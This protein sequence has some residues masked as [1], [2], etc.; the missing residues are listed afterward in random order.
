M[1]KK[2]G[3]KQEKKVNKKVN[4]KVIKGVSKKI[5]K[6]AN[7]KVIKEVKA[8]KGVSSG[9]ALNKP[10]KVPKKSPITK[11]TT[12]QK[13]KKILSKETWKK[14]RD[15]KGN[16][17]KGRKKSLKL[18]VKGDKNRYQAIVKTISDYN[19]KAGTPLKRKDL[20]K[21]YRR[22]RDTYSN[23]PLSV[24]IPQFNRIVIQKKAT[25][26]F[27]PSLTLG[28]PWYQ[29][30]DEMTAGFAQSYFR[31]N[32]EIV[33]DLGI[34]NPSIPNMRFPYSKI[35]GNYKKLYNNISFR[36]AVKMKSTYY[37]FEYDS[38]SSNVKKGIYVFVLR[39]VSSGTGVTQTP[40]QPIVKTPQQQAPTLPGPI[41]DLLG[42]NE[43]GEYIK[44]ITSLRDVQSSIASALKQ[45][46]LTYIQYRIEMDNIDEEIEELQNKI[47]NI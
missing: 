18:K 14:T 6:A 17:Q 23:I 13:A 29:F 24:L 34:V 19:K 7:K 5:N 9:K 21:E 41:G 12:K 22:V 2:K 1:K 45:K 25:R 44:Q 36:Q 26:Q 32:D 16:L 39:G 3:N 31:L 4:K 15:N 11:I 47:K 8:K 20:Y 28:M 35:I 46:Q 10:L 37:E 43:K 38:A 27:P 30:E 33:L 42:F 40:I